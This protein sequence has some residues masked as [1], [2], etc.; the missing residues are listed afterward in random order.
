[1]AF[2]ISILDLFM[3]SFNFIWDLFLMWVG[4]F[5]SPFI[6]LNL[7]WIIVPIWFA[8]FFAEFFQEKRKTSFGNAISNGVVP[9]WVAVDWTRFLV[10]KLTIENF[11]F[12][13]DI[14]F[15]LGLCVFIFLYGIMV[16]FM[17]ID[18]DK[19]TKYF[20]RIRVI[21]YFLLMFTPIIYG[22]A[23]LS[24]EIII[25]IGLFFPIFY[26]IIEIMDYYIPDPKAIIEDESEDNND[27]LKTQNINQLKENPSKLSDNIKLKN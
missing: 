3:T 22:V 2:W 5:K 25:S 9:I 23:E 24:G 11:N 16:I 18:G 7:L 17:G 13:M 14:I 19:S 12:E 6:N 26:Y 4:L 15:K 27:S 8:W 1:M 21:S 10:T 20:G